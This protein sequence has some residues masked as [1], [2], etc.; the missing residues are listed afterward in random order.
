MC[1]NYISCTQKP[2]L[3][4]F[5]KKQYNFFFSDLAVNFDIVFTY[6]R[7]SNYDLFRH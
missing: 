5:K 4:R 1:F 6:M 3:M 2:A 7:T